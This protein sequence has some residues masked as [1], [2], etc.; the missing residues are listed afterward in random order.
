MGVFAGFSELDDKVS[1]L[2]NSVHIR[3][4]CPQLAVHR[5][6]EQPAQRKQFHLLN[7]LVLSALILDLQLLLIHKK[8]RVN[9]LDGLDDF[10]QPTQMNLNHNILVFGELYRC[11][12]F[13]SRSHQGLFDVF[14]VDLVVGDDLRHG[15]LFF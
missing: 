6:E 10:S 14:I 8:L 7:F 4:N 9:I 15:L 13:H 3:P 12:F 1:L 5:F 11:V 2:R